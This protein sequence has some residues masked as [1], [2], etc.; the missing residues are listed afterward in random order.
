MRAV[1]IRML[2]RCAATAAIVGTLALFSTETPVARADGSPPSPTIQ[3]QPYKG[4]LLTCA[5]PSSP[6]D[7]AEWFWTRD[8][9]RIP[10][11]ASDTHV[12][13]GIDVGHRL[14]CGEIVS[15]AGVASSA[16]SAEV[17]IV[18][19]PV[20]IVDES[21]HVQT[22]SAL[23]VHG[24]VAADGPAAAG[25]VLVAEV[26]STRHAVG[27]QLSLDGHFSVTTNIWGLVPGRHRLRIQ[28]VPADSELHEPAQAIVTMIDKSPATYPFPRTLAERRP[29]VFD[30][31]PRFWNDGVQCSVG[32]RPRGAIAGWPLEPFH[33]QHALRA[34]LNELRNS[35]FHV[36]VDVMAL[37]GQR[38]YAIQSGR[39]HILRRGGI[40]ARVRVGNYVYWHLHLAVRDGQNVRAYHTILG[41]VFGYY[42]RHLH[43][44]EV[45]GAGRYLNPLRP[46]G[47]VL[48][49]WHDFEP[50]VIGRPTVLYDGTVTVDAFDPQSFTPT[51]Y[52]PT[53]VLAPAALAYR[54]TGPGGT[55]I[56]PLRWALRG[57]R[58]LP[59]SLASAVFAARARS[60]GFLCFATRPLCVPRWRYR[61][62]GGLAPKLPLAALPAH[63]RL[64]VYA[65]DWAGNATARDT[66]LQR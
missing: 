45:D 54:L 5:T 65:W 9:V 49:P 30:G 13:A 20:H 10:Q 44:S 25:I 28:F 56:G 8:G 12:V 58:W 1:S 3:G 38:V 52:Y 18:L 27:R 46:G 31:L 22:G 34:G 6:R 50:P 19:V 35:G 29:T 17:E 55:H 26:N 60:P 24:A 21:E 37:E 48:F 53:P 62:A 33:K 23:K 4:S 43:V 36:G 47:R 39:A 7:Q 14:A 42:V 16:S 64:T 63:F 41:H 61:L 66:W 32:C 51:M 15:N 59:P 40:E 11:A 2:G 57:S